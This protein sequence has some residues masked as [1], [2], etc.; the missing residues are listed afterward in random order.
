MR[1]RSILGA[2]IVGYDEWVIT[3]SATPTTIEKIKKLNK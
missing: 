2:I 3:I 1:R